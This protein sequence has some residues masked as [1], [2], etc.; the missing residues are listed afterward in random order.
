MKQNRGG[1][2][3]CSANTPKLQEDMKSKWRHPEGFGTLRSLSFTEVGL[4]LCVGEHGECSPR[5]RQE[6]PGGLLVELAGVH[7]HDHAGCRCCLDQ[8]PGTDVGHRYIYI[9][10]FLQ[11]FMS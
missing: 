10:V 9:A 5:R 4:R 7:S 2:V 11:V 6:S 1:C 3:E 8:T